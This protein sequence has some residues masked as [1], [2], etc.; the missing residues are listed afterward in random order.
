MLKRCETVV[1][2]IKREI[3]IVISKQNDLLNDFGVQPSKLKIQVELTKNQML[4]DFSTNVMMSL[5]LSP[6]N[7]LKFAYKIA[8]A[9]S[10]RFFAKVEVAK[11]G[12]LNIFLSEN[13]NSKFLKQILKQQD[14]FGKFKHKKIFYNIEFVSANPTGLL[15]IGHARNAAIGDTLS[16]I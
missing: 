14:E 10:K 1:E 7:V 2:L 15:H 12:F 6:E 9:L 13:L 4:G 11:P 3:L 5:G 8:A 16:R